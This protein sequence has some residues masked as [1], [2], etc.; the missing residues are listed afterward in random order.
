MILLIGIQVE[1]KK[2]YFEVCGFQK[3]RANFL[4]HDTMLAQ[5][6]LSSCVCVSA[7]LSLTRQYCTEMAKH[8]IT[9]NNAR[10]ANF[11]M[12][13]ISAKFQWGSPHR[14]HQNRGGV[15]YNWQFRLISRYIW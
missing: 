10:D 8:R 9:Q 12:L 7:C 6:M 11:L 5:Y 2:W 4:P 15:D 14:G 13:K 3:S 1:C